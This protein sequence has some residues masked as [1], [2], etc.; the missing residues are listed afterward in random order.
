MSRLDDEKKQFAKRKPLAV[1]QNWLYAMLEKPLSDRV[2]LV[3]ATDAS[4]ICLKPLDL[5]QP[6]SFCL[7]PET[8]SLL[9]VLGNC[10]VLMRKDGQQSLVRFRVLR[11]WAEAL[12]TLRHFS[13]QLCLR[14]VT[15]RVKIPQSSCARKSALAPINSVSYSLD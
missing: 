15:R 3:P 6:P 9:V 14:H 10:N 2:R 11:H 7:R 13:R 8:L 4:R 12:Q 5:P 1:L